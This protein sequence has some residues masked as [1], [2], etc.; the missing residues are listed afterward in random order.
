MVLGFFAGSGTV[1]EAAH[2][3]GRRFILID[4]NLEAMEVMAK[5]FAHI[6]NVAFVHFEPASI[7]RQSKETAVQTSFTD[8]IP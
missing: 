2:L 5:R 1:G 7:D 4:N 6:P 3:L 8:L